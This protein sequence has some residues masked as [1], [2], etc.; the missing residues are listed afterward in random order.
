[1]KRRVVLLCALLALWSGAVVARLAQIQIGRHEHYVRRAERQQ[2]RT[3]EIGALRGSILDATGRILA[4]SVTGVSVY[5]DPQA[6]DDPAAVARRLATI[7]ELGVDRAD[8]AERL[9]GRGEFAWVA[10]QLPVEIGDRV[11]AL[12]IPGIYFLEEFRRSYPKGFL[13]ANVLGFVSIDGHGLAGVEHSL[14]A[15]TSGR[16]GRA[17]IL[18]DARR[19]MYL[20]GSAAGS[21][22]GHNVV[23]TID[24]V[25]QYIAEKAL[26]RAMDEWAAPSGS[27]VVLDPND[28][29]ILA[30][31]SWPTFDPNAFGRY[32]PSAWRNRAVQDLY[33]PGSTFKIVTAA[34]GIEEGVVTPSQMVDCGDGAIEIANVRIHEH[35]GVKFGLLPFEQ[36]IARSSNI[37]TIR[38]A[39]ALGEQRFYRWVRR[40]GFGEQ[41]G[42][43][44]PGEAAGILRPPE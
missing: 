19:G 41:T 22:D 43:D 42:V 31:A 37:G 7:P 6:I 13:A 17:T 30:L 11:R 14:D 18:R 33:E 12:E 15:W 8:L 21:V 10:R 5:A 9:A 1:M 4:E 38:V 35:G 26:R 40:F 2:E 39:L 32:A 34:A 44:L 28:G 29:A 3:I 20:V 24:E 27:V 16:P 36:V 25:I 23:L